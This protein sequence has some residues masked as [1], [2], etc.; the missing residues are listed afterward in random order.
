MITGPDRCYEGKRG[1][2]GVCRVDV[3]ELAARYPLE[4]RLDLW[5]RTPRPTV[6]VA[7]FDWGYD[8]IGPSQLALA[9]LADATGDDQRALKNLLAFKRRMIGSLPRLRWTV[10]RETVLLVLNAIER[11]E[12]RPAHGKWNANKQTG[13]RKG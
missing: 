8:G 13:A 7:T 4:P 11:D 9:M 1:L 10:S 3:V 5:N 2:D 6:A 12:S